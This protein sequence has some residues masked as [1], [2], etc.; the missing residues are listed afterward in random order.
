M[1]K[2]EYRESLL[3]V[4]L[5]DLFEVMGRVAELEIADP[6][7]GDDALAERA[8]PIAAASARVD[9]AAELFPDA[10]AAIAHAKAYLENNANTADIRAA[11]SRLTAVI[12]RETGREEVPLA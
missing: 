2:L 10:A 12:D 11:L 9:A 8:A 5:L 7:V 1:P 4:A 6:S 3:A